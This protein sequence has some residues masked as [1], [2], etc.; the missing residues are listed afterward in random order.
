MVRSAYIHFVLRS[1]TLTM[2]SRKNSFT[3]HNKCI[4]KLISSWSTFETSNPVASFRICQEKFYPDIE[5][6]KNEKVPL[7]VN[8]LSYYETV[9]NK[10]EQ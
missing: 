9:Q 6:K 7:S 2:G 3:L 10:K 8:I 5:T 1:H 4:S